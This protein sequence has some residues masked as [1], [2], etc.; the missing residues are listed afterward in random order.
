MG[1]T[2][3]EGEIQTTHLVAKWIFEFA[4][5]ESYQRFMKESLGGILCIAI[6]YYT[7]VNTSCVTA[8]T[9][10]TM[11]DEEYTLFGRPIARLEKPFCEKCAE[12]LSSNKYTFCFRCHKERD[13][14]CFD[15]LR[16]PGVYRRE[17]KDGNC[18]SRVIRKFKYHTLSDDERCR[19]AEEL[20]RLLYKYVSNT[21]EI[22][23]NVGCL[24]PVPI[25]E[26]E[27]IRKGFNH[28]GMITREFSE[29]I[30]IEVEESNLIKIRETKPQV[31]LNRQER[32]ENVKDAFEVRFP[33]RIKGKKVLMID[34]VA[35]SCFT[36]D[37]CAKKLKEAGATAVNILVLARNTKIAG[38]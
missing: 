17:K 27:E 20:A 18:L 10:K 37:E 32:R 23:N 13:T 15:I 8:R 16:A 28:I 1:I 30:G 38:E 36:I 34:D 6:L 35:T 31:E 11:D 21:P 26:K 7:T 33:K 9:V 25:T 4:Q 2:C 12:S 5:K 29:R 24:V 19:I 14:L 3:D 22:V